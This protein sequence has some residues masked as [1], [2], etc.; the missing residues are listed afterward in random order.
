MILPNG[1]R[2]TILLTGA[3]AP[4]GAVI[5]RSLSE[6]AAFHTVPVAA[7]QDV[8]PMLSDVGVIVYAAELSA[9]AASDSSVTLADYRKANTAEPLVLARQA[10]NAGVKRFIYIS[11]A[12][13]HGEYSAG[14]KVFSEKDEPV[15]QSPYAV[16]KYEAEVALQALAEETGLELVIVRPA[17]LYGFGVSTG[18]CCLLKHCTSWLP[19]PFDLLSNAHSVL[20]VGNLADFI[21]R[22]V[23]NPAAANQTFLVSDGEDVSLSTLVAFIRHCMGRSPGLLPV[24]VFLLRL[25]GSLVG[26][27]KAVQQLLA[28]FQVDSA[29]ARKLLEWSPR[30]SVLKAIEA[31]VSEFKHGKR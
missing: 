19:L 4:V 13:V 18:F 12:K 8:A 25:V 7:G 16:S 15:P 9:D 10:A 27:R 3:T 29:K 26:K 14:Y 21:T 2:E 23:L 17:P 31:T 22:C 11:S 5:L 28:D 1:V 6:N 20:Y 24:P 30:Y